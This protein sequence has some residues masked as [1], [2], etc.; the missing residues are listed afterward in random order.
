MATAR[1]TLAKAR[2]IIEM[3]GCVLLSDNVDSLKCLVAIRCVCTRV[4]QK[5]P[6]TFVQHP[7]CDNC[8]RQDVREIR[9]FVRSCRRMLHKLRKGDQKMAAI[10][11]YGQA[12]IKRMLESFPGEPAI[13]SGKWG[14]DHVRPLAVLA[15]LGLRDQVI[16]NAIDNILPMS[17]EE[18]CHKGAKCDPC[19]VVAWLRSKGFEPP[20]LSQTQGWA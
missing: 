6:K 8:R 2:N 7:F 18:N 13:R 17:K 16:A 4:I 15:R 10:L 20:A 11:G 14:F 19:E 12:E 9:C 5:S 1:G 3:F